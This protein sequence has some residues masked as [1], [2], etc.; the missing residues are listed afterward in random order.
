MEN[1]IAV[2][3]TIFILLPVVA[4]SGGVLIDWVKGKINHSD[5]PC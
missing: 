3:L 5:G 2:F 1:K 4:I